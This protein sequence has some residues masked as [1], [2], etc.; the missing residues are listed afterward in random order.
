[1]WTQHHC[2][3]DIIISGINEG[4]NIGKSKI[5][6]GTVSAALAAC[7]RGYKAYAQSCKE[8]TLNDTGEPIYFIKEILKYLIFEEKSYSVNKS[9]I[10]IISSDC[11]IKILEESIVIDKSAI[12]NPIK[13]EGKYKLR[14]KDDL[15]PLGM[16]GET[17]LIGSLKI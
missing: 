11:G 4:L 5:Y 16:F 3:P 7:N 14:M 6:S 2:N 15:K 10:N 9:N 12:Y 1:M 8:G 17:I 13:L